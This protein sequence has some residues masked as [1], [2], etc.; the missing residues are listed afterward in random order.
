MLT[1]SLLQADAISFFVTRKYKKNPRNWWKYEKRTCSERPEEFQWNF[2]KD[3]T[4]KN[5]KSHKK[6]RFHPLFRGYIFGK[7]TGGQIDFESFAP[8][9]LKFEVRLV[10]LSQSDIQI[11]YGL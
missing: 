8:A 5:I 11:L 7:T 1:S 2:R 10:D 3:V 9:Y 4:Y 6:A